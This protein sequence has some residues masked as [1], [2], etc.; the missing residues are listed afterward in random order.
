MY[1]YAIYIVREK[2]GKKKEMRRGVESKKTKSF[3]SAMK[4]NRGVESFISLLFP[5]STHDLS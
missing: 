5:S 2:R 1:V 4:M 3:D